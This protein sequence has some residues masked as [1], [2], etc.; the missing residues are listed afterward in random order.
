MLRQDQPHVPNAVKMYQI[1]LYGPQNL[2]EKSFQPVSVVRGNI[3]LRGG[4]GM[5][6]RFRSWQHRRV[7][8]RKILDILTFPSI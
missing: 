3:R 1:G 7:P 8:R 4:A 6:C 5:R 2:M